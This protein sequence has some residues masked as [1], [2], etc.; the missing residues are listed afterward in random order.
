M[1]RKNIFYIFLLFSIVF[2]SSCGKKKVELTIPEDKLIKIFFDLHAAENII[3]R[4]SAN[5]K[6]SLSIAYRDQ[7]FKLYNVDKKEFEKNLKSLQSH[8]GYFKD[9]YEK[10]NKYGDKLLEEERN[11][12]S[13]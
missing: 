2:L 1:K 7:I 3:S 13:E 6:D 4:A 10:V 8:P 5:E 9:F 12:K 11:K